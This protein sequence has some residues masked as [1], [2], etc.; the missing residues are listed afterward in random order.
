MSEYQPSELVRD[1]TELT[2]LELRV[3]KN[4]LGE[5]GAMLRFGDANSGLALKVDHLGAQACAL[6][7]AAWELLQN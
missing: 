7:R 2:A 3:M 6:E 5:L 1:Q 4:R